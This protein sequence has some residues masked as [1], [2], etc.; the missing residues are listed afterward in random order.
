MWPNT[1]DSNF[2]LG[3]VHILVVYIIDGSDSTSDKFFVVFD[4]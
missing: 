1:M 4:K 2:E 3:V